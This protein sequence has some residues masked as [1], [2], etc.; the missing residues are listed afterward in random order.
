MYVCVCGC[1]LH[2][3][4]AGSIYLSAGALI[5]FGDKTEALRRIS[6]ALEI[7]PNDCVL[8]ANVARMYVTLG[9]F[10]LAFGFIEKAR[11][12][13][14]LPIDWLRRDPDM[15]PIRDDPRYIEILKS[16]N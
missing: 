14:V 4:C 11:S 8:L 3:F 5:E 9:D 13:G 7:S 6:R 12:I 16:H 10:D 15:D 1:A 2:V